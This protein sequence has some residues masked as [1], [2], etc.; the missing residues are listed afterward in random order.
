MSLICSAAWA[1]T[2]TALRAG[3]TGLFDTTV[4]NIHDM[5]REGYTVM[6]SH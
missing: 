2:R 4:A 6:R 3:D 1:R 5:E